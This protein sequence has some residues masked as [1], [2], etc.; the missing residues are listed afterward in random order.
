MTPWCPDPEILRCHPEAWVVGCLFH[1]QPRRGQSQLR[2]QA[3]GEQVWS[4]ERECE[5][6]VLHPIPPPND[7][8]HTRETKEASTP[9][10]RKFL[11]LWYSDYV[12]ALKALTPT[13]SWSHTLLE[14]D[15]VLLAYFKFFKVV[16]LWWAKSN[17]VGVGLQGIWTQTL[18]D[19]RKVPSQRFTSRTWNKSGK[20]CFLPLSLFLPVAVPFSPSNNKISIFS[21][22]FLS[23]TLLSH[24]PLFPEKRAWGYRKQEIGE[25]AKED[26][27]YNMGKLKPVTPLIKKHWSK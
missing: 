2:G 13:A 14:R 20:V 4:V 12:L 15:E 21:S 23:D 5:A 18:T 3:L 16:E 17:W 1:H 8:P 22:H 6:W 24:H 10:T 25:R 7:W 19:I 26:G 9:N 11:S 27:V